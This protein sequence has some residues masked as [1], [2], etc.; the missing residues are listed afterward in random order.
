VHPNAPKS[1]AKQVNNNLLLSPNAEIDTKPELQIYTDD[2]QCS[3]GATVGKLDEQALFYLRS[4][5][6]NYDQARSLLIYTFAAEVLKNISDANL[7][8]TLQQ[9]ILT[10]LPVTTWLQEICH[11][12]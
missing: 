6:L 11:D 5:G 8:N 9:Q 2:V 3:H 10:Y 4:R 1:N 7:R 12:I